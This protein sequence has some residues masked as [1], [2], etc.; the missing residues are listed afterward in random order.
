VLSL[1]SVPADGARWCVPSFAGFRERGFVDGRRALDAK[2]VG[3]VQVAALLV[4]E[5]SGVPLPVTSSCSPPRT[6]RPVEERGPAG[7][8]A[9][10]FD[11]LMSCNSSAHLL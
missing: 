7:F 4:L 8:V 2:G 5:R 10:R 1:E 9:H 3:V 6:R 11:V